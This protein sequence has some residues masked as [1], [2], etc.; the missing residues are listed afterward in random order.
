[1]KSH[2]ELKP[3]RRWRIIDLNDLPAPI[4]KRLTTLGLIPGTEIELIRVAPLGDPWQVRI[5]GS[6]FSLSWDTLT[7]LN[8]EVVHD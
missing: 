6:L 7:Q 5:R 2:P 3:G 4:Q 1:M 8:K